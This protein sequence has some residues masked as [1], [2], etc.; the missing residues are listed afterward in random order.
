MPLEYTHL[1]LEK[2][3]DN[4]AIVRLDYHN[5]R[6][7]K[8]S[9]PF[10][11]D[12]EADVKRIASDA[13]IEAVVVISAKKDNFIVGADAAELTSLR[14]AA[15]AT[16]LIRRAQ[17]I[18]D[19]I[20]KSSKPWVA[21]IH[22]AC[23]GGGLEFALACH[24]ILATDD[25]VTRLAL[26]EV[27]LG[28]IPAGG[29]CQRLPEK[30]GL[31][32]A[33]DMI[34]TGKTVFAKKAGKMGL[35]DDVVIPYALERQAVVAA[36]RLL[37]GGGA[38]TRKKSIQEQALEE[39]APARDI[40]FRKAS[41][42]VMKKTRG[43]YPAPL[44][45]LECVKTGLS[46]GREEGFAREAELVGQLVVGDVSKELIHL[47]FAMTAKKKNSLAK[48]AIK[49]KTVGVL[50]AGL[51]GAGVA[52]VTA[53]TAKTP[54]I[55]KDVSPEGVAGGFKYIFRDIEKGYK[56]K[57][58]G[59]VERDRFMAMIDG[60][61]DYSHFQK[62][63]LVIEAVFEDLDIKRKVLAQTEAATKDHCVF[64]SNTSAIPISK[65]A[66]K[67]KRPENVLGMHYFSP[68]Q[69][70]PLL[71]IITTEKT[72]Q[73]ALKTAVTLGLAQ[74]KTIIVVKDSPGFYTTRILAPYLN[75]AQLLLGQGGEMEKIDK[76]MVAYGFP[77]GP[78]SLMDEV[79]MDVAAH[80]GQDLGPFFA[81]RGGKVANLAGKMADGGFLG[82][83]NKKGFYLYDIHQK[84]SPF[85]FSLIKGAGKKKKIPNNKA[86]EFIPGDRKE[87]D[88][89][90]IQL[91][92]TFIFI[93]EAAL[94]LQEE[95]IKS[96]T[97][98][99]LGAILG[100]GFPPFRGGP[101]R[102]IDSYG[103]NNLISRM[104]FYEKEFGPRFKPARI[105]YDYGKKNKK[106][107]K[108]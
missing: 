72:S 50:G 9:T 31:Q 105:L 87:L 106:F 100:L 19:R 16:A 71:E 68:V 93:N 102:F 84:T 86:Y 42:M 97:D 79:G 65:I 51:M 62:A 85:P 35:V 37:K 80:V 11:R 66:Q 2:R 74:G 48:G 99:D 108:D 44:Y 41:Q 7:N 56:K 39:I 13:D 67:S 12:L 73:Q 81:K 29:G 32:Q 43:N 60:V 75:E 57:V 21:A 27:K 61:T 20:E 94:C 8:I 49:A 77:I 34:L 30:I 78:V 107:Y 15:E 64:A 76:A 1:K 89:E 45:A 83:K 33:L 98:G 70:M 3:S 91:R 36:H 92:S 28:I 22:G 18:F 4:I 54:V 88:S 96:P 47:F 59:Q 90:M 5:E 63:D 58:Y 38:K 53:K 24:Y 104:E 14:N 17:K 52:L 10:G 25:S 26:P 101:F 6:V 23:M 40:I 95:I 55:L 46:Q 82:R 103:V 69:A